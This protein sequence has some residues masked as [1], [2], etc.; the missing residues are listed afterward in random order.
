[1]SPR[2]GTPASAI[3]FLALTFDPIA[4]IAP[5]GGPI[6]VSPASITDCANSAFSERN[7]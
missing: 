6:Q 2:T 5:G 4:S 7:P 1:M 3:N